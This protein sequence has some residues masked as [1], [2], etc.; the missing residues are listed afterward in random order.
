MH[1][2]TIGNTLAIYA[3][4]IPTT[5]TPLQNRVGELYS[6]IRFMDTVCAQE[7]FENMLFDIPRTNIIHARI[8]SPT[9][10]A[11]RVRANFRPGHLPIGVIVVSPLW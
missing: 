2:S 5:R 3:I 9:I 6:L 7:S 11:S 8:P 4:F 1:D 10:F